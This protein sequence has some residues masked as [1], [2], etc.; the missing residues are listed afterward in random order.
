[1]DSL[2]SL[3][4]SPAAR[5]ALRGGDYGALLRLARQARGLTQAQAGQLAGYSAATISRFETSARRLAD[6]ETLRRLAAALNITPELFGLTPESRVAGRAASPL[7]AASLTK[8]VTARPQDGDEV[9]RRELLAGLTGLAGAL[10]L[11][12]PGT[13]AGPGTDP[14]ASNL[15]AILDRPQ[16]LCRPGCPSPPCEKASAQRGKRSRPATIRPSPGNCPTW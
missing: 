11:P 9:R 8:V 3:F 1:M 4:A 12:L 7:G 10:L 6:I 13:P 16:R 2:S 5:D 14:L 15:E